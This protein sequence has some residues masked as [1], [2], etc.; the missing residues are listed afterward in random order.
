MSNK[1]AVISTRLSRE[2]AGRPGLSHETQ[3]RECRDY[4][5]ARGYTVAAVYRDTNTSGGVPIMDREGAGA[6]VDHAVRVHGVLVVSRMDRISRDTKDL[7]SLLD[8]EL[9][10]KADIEFV[11][12][13]ID[14]STVH[15]RG[16][17]TA[18]M[19][20]GCEMTRRQISHSTR[21]GLRTRRIQGLFPANRVP[22]YGYVIGAQSTVVS[23]TKTPMVELE[24]NPKERRIMLL[25]VTLMSP[26]YNMTWP[27]ICREVNA[28]D[29]R[30]RDGSHWESTPLRIAVLAFQRREMDR[31]G[32]VDSANPLDRVDEFEGRA[33]LTRAMPGQENREES[34]TED[35]YRTNRSTGVS[36]RRKK[37]RSPRA[38]KARNSARDRAPH[39]DSEVRTGDAVSGCG[40]VAGAD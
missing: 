22:P 39:G 6:A 34:N 16:V 28:R 3:E 2:E 37:S 13:G 32:R 30:R 35:A 12:E 23:R 9:A 5:R 4:C 15:G 36:R 33:L 11:Q 21:A 25:G 26:P 10:G 7:L 17:L 8:D 24:Y 18:I 1:I 40:S 20:L 14:T 31:F 27:Q 29:Y 19:G 38:D